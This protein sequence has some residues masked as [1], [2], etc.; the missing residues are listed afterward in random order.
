MKSPFPGM[1]PFRATEEDVPLN[2]QSLIDRCYYHGRY[3]DLNYTAEPNP[4][5]DPE[6][7]AWS[8]ELLCKQ[9][10]RLRPARIRRRNR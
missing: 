4:P 1:D 6:D 2:L 3:E 5:L 7:A 9:G 8:N 10:L